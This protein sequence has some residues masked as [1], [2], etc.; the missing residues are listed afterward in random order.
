MTAIGDTDTFFNAKGPIAVTKS[1]T[2]DLKPYHA[3]LDE[4]TE[5]FQDLLEAL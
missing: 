1:L 4:K 2:S 3:D 5:G